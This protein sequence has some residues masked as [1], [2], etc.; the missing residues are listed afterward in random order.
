M[1]SGHLQQTAERSD[2]M[3]SIVV[4]AVVMFYIHFYVPTN[5]GP[6]C[7]CYL[8]A[9]SLAAIHSYLCVEFVR[10]NMDMDWWCGQQW[11]LVLLCV[12]SR[13]FI[14]GPSKCLLRDNGGAGMTPSLFVCNRYSRLLA[15][16]HPFNSW[17]ERENSIITSNH[18]H[19]FC[20]ERDKIRMARI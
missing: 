2:R 7:C 3:T 20:S 16:T 11:Q 6:S 19:Q 14:N 18:H 9:S 17:P 1:A 5:N 12:A 8:F 13:S 15:Q 4:R 10:I